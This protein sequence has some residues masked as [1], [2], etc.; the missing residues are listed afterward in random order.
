MSIL[1]ELQA[2]ANLS[3]AQVGRLFG[4]PARSVYAW[5][6]TVPDRY[7]N[8]YDQVVTTITALGDTPDERK[9][10]LLDSTQGQS[11]MHQ[12]IEQAPRNARIQYS[13]PV[14][15]LLGLDQPPPEQSE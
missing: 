10:R 15:H 9:M 5:R 3:A 6:E 12:L 13:V 1:Q 11:V 7:F 4:V 2:L 8:Q 14:H